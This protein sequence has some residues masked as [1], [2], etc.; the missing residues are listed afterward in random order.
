MRCPSTSPD[1]TDRQGPGSASCCTD[2]LELQ[3][4]ASAWSVLSTC[5]PGRL[6]VTHTDVSCAKPFGTRLIRGELPASAPWIH[7]GPAERR[8][9]H[10][11]KLMLLLSV[12]VKCLHWKGK[13][14]ITN[15]WM[16][17]LDGTSISVSL[18]HVRDCMA[19]GMLKP[20][21][22]PGRTEDQALSHSP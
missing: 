5:T 15:T 1:G 22:G 18:A 21:F 17:P 12:A 13:Y 14:L 16:S 9:N 20:L 19:L 6:W 7:R 8:Q 2:E 4:Q 3:V 11:T 10:G